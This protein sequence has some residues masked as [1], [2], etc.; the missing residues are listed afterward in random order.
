MTAAHTEPVPDRILP[1]PV[2]PATAISQVTA[3][4]QAR[5]V[6]EVQAAIVVAQQVPRDKDRALAE[7]RDSCSRMALANRAFYEVKNRGN[8][9][10]VHLARELARTWGNPGYG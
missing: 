8:G 10:S 6:A 1:V 3:V 7:M 5:A 9:P 2:P 4:E